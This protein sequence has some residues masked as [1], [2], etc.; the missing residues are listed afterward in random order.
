MEVVHEKWFLS[1]AAVS[2]VDVLIPL[3]LDSPAAVALPLGKRPTVHVSRKSPTVHVPGKY[4][5]AVA[6]SVG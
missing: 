4:S 3:A 2:S 6:L 5:A 1:H